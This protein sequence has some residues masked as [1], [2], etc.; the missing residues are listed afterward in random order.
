MGLAELLDFIRLKITGN[1]D[2]P[3]IMIIEQRQD[4]AYMTGI[5]VVIQGLNLPHRNSG[6]CHRGPVKQRPVLNALA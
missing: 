5:A 6:R 3:E 4:I 1:I 2:L